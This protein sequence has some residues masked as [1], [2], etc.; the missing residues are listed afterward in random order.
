MPR[1]SSEE[2][3]DNQTIQ[4]QFD[5]AKKWVGFQASGAKAQFPNLDDIKPANQSELLKFQG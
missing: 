5:T 3:R 1:V 4:T 2:Q